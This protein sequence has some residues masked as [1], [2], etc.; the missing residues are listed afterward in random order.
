MINTVPFLINGKKKVYT[1]SYFI[2]TTFTFCKSEY[3]KRA[4]SFD[5]EWITLPGEA[6]KIGS[7]YDQSRWLEN[8][9]QHF[10]FFSFNIE[11]WLD[12]IMFELVKEKILR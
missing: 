2:L 9:P 6:M 4:Y 10:S 7:G 8:K 11:P 12:S 3:I 5:K 1:I